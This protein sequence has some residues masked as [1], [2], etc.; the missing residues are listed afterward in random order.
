MAF[1]LC[2]SF[3]NLRR[4]FQLEDDKVHETLVSFK[5]RH[6]SARSMTLAIQSQHELDQLQAWVEESFSAVPNCDLPPQ[7]FHHLKAPF[8]VPGEIF[9]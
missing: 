3:D 4:L 7:T 1:L 5:D 9:E 8:S 6:Y 2:P